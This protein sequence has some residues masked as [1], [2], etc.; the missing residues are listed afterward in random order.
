MQ[1]YLITLDEIQRRHNSPYKYIPLSISVF[2]PAYAI[3]IAFA[4]AFW[5]KR[6]FEVA[7]AIESILV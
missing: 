1:A 2:S 6:G 4:I 3:G 5:K 7:K